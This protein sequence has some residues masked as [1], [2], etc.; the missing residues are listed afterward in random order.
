MDRSAVS[1]YSLLSELQAE[2]WQA[3]AGGRTGRSCSRIGAV[4]TV[5]H[6]DVIV[7]VNIAVLALTLVV[8]VALGAQ[9]SLHVA[10]SVCRVRSFFVADERLAALTV[11][12]AHLSLFNARHT[13]AR[14]SGT[15]AVLP[16]A[17]IIIAAR[18]EAAAGGTRL[19]TVQPP[20]SFLRRS[21]S[22]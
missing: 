19:F 11:A 4:S 8:V 20:T 13:N 9:R 14:R 2:K 21:H 10:P 16:V 22:G 6:D 15:K 1:L 7:P 3:T 17:H 12:L 18:R 5:T